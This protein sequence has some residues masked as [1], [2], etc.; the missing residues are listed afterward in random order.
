M[1]EVTERLLADGIIT[2]AEADLAFSA[3]AI[4]SLTGIS[5]GCEYEVLRSAGPDTPIIGPMWR[6]DPDDRAILRDVVGRCVEDYDVTVHQDGWYEL[7][8]PAFKSAVAWT[9]LTR[10]VFRLGLLPNG[11]SGAVTEHLNT[12]TQTGMEVLHGRFD[13]LAR[14]VRSLEQ[15]RG[16]TASRL[17]LPLRED[18][19]LVVKPDAEYAWNSRGVAGIV[20]QSMANEPGWDGRNRLELRTLGSFNVQQQERIERLFYALSLGALAPEGS[21]AYNIYRHYDDY[22]HDYFI[23]HHLPIEVPQALLESPTD[24]IALGTYIMPFVQHLRDGGANKSLMLMADQTAGRLLEEFG[25]H[26]MTLPAYEIGE[27]QTHAKVVA[28]LARLFQNF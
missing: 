14:L 20:L 19:L 3:E 9:V 16:T 13:M 8:T 25:M 28:R 11:T 4:G 24:R 21:R 6:Y 17:Q 10:A 15:Q 27:Q 12:S 2:Q 18:D 26:N 22:V 1:G 23:A 5:A 7:A